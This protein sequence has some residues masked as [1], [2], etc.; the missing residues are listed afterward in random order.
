MW[1]LI[2]AAAGTATLAAFVPNALQK[3][4]CQLTSLLFA[5]F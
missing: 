4:Y 3:L 2:P 1:F 5:L